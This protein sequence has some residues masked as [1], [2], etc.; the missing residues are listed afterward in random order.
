MSW[1]RERKKSA[2]RQIDRYRQV[3]RQVDR[4]MDIYIYIYMYIIYEII[5]IKLQFSYVSKILKIKTCA[6]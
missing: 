4:Q 3:G 1:N 2:Y 6:F 5:Y